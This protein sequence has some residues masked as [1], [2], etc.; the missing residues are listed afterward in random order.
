MGSKYAPS[1]GHPIGNITEGVE[2]ENSESE[3]ESEVLQ[4]EP[5]E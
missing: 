4:L 2:I 3:S 5:T 1:K